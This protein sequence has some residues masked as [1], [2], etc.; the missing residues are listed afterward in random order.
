MVT[1][2]GSLPPQQRDDVQGRRFPHILDRIQAS[3]DLQLVRLDDSPG[4][5]G[6]PGANEPAISL[7]DGEQAIIALVNELT[8]HD[9]RKN[10]RK[11][12]DTELTPREKDVLS[13]V[14]L[15]H[16]NKEIAASLFISIHTVISHRKN[17]TEKL[18]I[19]S[20]S[21]LTV[22]AVLNKIID[23][24]TLDTDLLI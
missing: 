1:D 9:G 6:R 21:G 13:L 11:P 23:T 18:G 7:D 3:N 4:T 2:L 22:Y 15:G 8:G 24:D 19:K 20:I 5:P 14:A 12:D 17:I 16:S 10:N